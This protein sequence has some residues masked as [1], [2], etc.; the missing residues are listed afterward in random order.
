MDAWSE[1]MVPAARRRL[2]TDVTLSSLFLLFSFFL[3]SPFNPSRLGSS[4]QL[5]FTTGALAVHFIPV[6]SASSC[7]SRSSVTWRE[8]CLKRDSY[9]RPSLGL[10]SYRS[11]P[12]V[13][14]AASP[15]QP[16]SFRTAFCQPKG[17]STYEKVSNRRGKAPSKRES[18]LPSSFLHRSIALQE[19]AFSRA[20][21]VAESN[22]TKK[23]LSTTVATGCP[24]SSSSRYS[25]S[26]STPAVSLT[27]SSSSPGT[28]SSPSPSTSSSLFARPPPLSPRPHPL[29]LLCGPPCSGKGSVASLLCRR[30]RLEHVSTGDLLREYLQ[31]QATAESSLA[32][33]NNEETEESKGNRDRERSH[34]TSKDAAEALKSGKLVSDELILQLLHARLES[35]MRVGRGDEKE[36]E[37]KEGRLKNS[38]AYGVV[39]EG[40]PRTA[41]QVDLLRAINCHPDAIVALEVSDAV[42]FERM[43]GR[44]V[45]PSTGEVYGLANPPPKELE[46]CLVRR[47]D[48]SAEVL[49]TRIKIYR[50]SWQD[51]SQKLL[52]GQAA[53]TLGGGT[54]NEDGRREENEGLQESTHDAVENQDILAVIDGGKSVEEV[55]SDVVSFLKRKFGKDKIVER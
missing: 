7:L 26:D 5:P 52:P 38:E 39:L 15:A 49:E 22:L 24:F 46:H 53:S 35:L 18:K 20:G 28:Y 25:C 3:F 10:P 30:L 50:D 47:S 23:G 55:Y 19:N 40:F 31:Q 14:G 32:H 4:N 13:G 33:G 6:S 54:S 37:E 48:D 51:I 8:D 36:E 11:H 9:S 2:S 29:I 16:L 45:N 44:L 42:L 34:E 41:R 21:G 1:R 17:R 43:G 27:S 12:G